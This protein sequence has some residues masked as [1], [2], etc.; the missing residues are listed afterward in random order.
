MNAKNYWQLIIIAILIISSSCTEN[1]LCLSGQSNIQAGLYSGSSGVAKDTSLNGF[2]L[3]GLN[4]PNDSILIDSV[5]T[6]SMHMPVDINIDS[7]KFVIR[8]K[9]IASDLNDTLIFYYQ[10]QLSYVS[11]ECG[12]TYN[13][14]LDSVKYTNNFVDSVVI[15]YASVLYNE[16]LENVKIY[17]EP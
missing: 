9:A 8:E 4:A 10:R 5:K 2:Y 16:N 6:K 3:W 11:G 15:D 13:L 7:S 17:I 12:F 14:N 1:D